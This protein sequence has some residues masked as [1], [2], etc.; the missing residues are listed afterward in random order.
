MA[1]N[2]KTTTQASKKESQKKAPKAPQAPVENVQVEEVKT[3]TTV[4][5]PEVLK[6][7][8]ASG[9]DAN[10][11]TELLGLASK[12]LTGPQAAA[13]YGTLVED[14]MDR[15]V[16]AGIVSLIGE[17][18]LKG[19]DTFAIALK[20]T[21]YPML[22]AVAK[23]MN[24]TLPDVK[25][26]EAKGETV[27][28]P[29]TSAEVSE[30]AK[31]QLNEEAEITKK[32]AKNEIE[33]DPVKVAHL[34]EQA[35]K[36]ALKYIFVTSPKVNK[37]SVK[38]TLTSVVDFMHDY[39]IEQA[40]Q[41]E[42]STDAMNKLEDRNMYEWL[43]DIR[44]YVEPTTI[45][46]GIGLGLINLTVIEKSP[47]S[48]FLTLRGS[49]IDPETKQ[50]VWDDQSIAHAT[51][52]FIEFIC[53]SEIAKEQAAIENLD[54]KEKDYK[55]IVAKHES[56]IERYKSVLSYVDNISFDI[57]TE[58]S[59]NSGS[60]AIN[61]AYGRIHSQ[62][63]RDCDVAVPRAKYVGLVGN[64][65]QRAGIIL[66]LFLPSTEYNKNYSES[67]LVEVKEMPLE[68]WEKLQAEKKKQA[69]EEKKAKS[70]NA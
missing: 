5:N 64:L 13:K 4:I 49:L 46:K 10:H 62:Y 58:E 54:K 11:L 23:D 27:V 17:H 6:S 40:R 35:L 43:T 16:A 63:Y 65:C 20:T 19:D 33:L 38:D 52:F 57:C 47:L 39:R 68:E 67:N 28:V 25:C 56:V 59:Y 14:Q 21:A 29:A 18:A 1:N 31:Q 22:Q 41:A 53:N 37:F 32:G 9:L 12:H 48:A 24:I 42:N 66:N 7:T 15:I 44:K 2:K 3:S 55:D 26:L 69:A 36:D 45:T 34:D 30:E 61:K 51:R 70:K 60:E 8:K 50:P